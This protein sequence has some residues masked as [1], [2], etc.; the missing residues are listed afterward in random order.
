MVRKTRAGRRGG[1]ASLKRRVVLLACPNTQILDAAGPAEVFARA[2][3]VLS[4]RNHADPG[5][6]I[7][8]VSTGAKTVTTSAGI[9]LVSHQ[10]I[11]EVKGSIDTLLDVGGP[12]EV[13]GQAR[14]EGQNDDESVLFHNCTIAQS[15]SPVRAENGMTYIPEYTFEDHPE[16]DIL[17]IPGGR[18]CRRR[19]GMAR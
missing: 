15:A 3:A 8:L 12:Y 9:S 10:P 7:E 2:G 18:G 13:F 6:R 17:V 11:E 5:Y 19:N 16:V 14:S 1:S 4:L